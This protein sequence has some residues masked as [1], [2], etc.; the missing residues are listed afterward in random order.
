M[1]NLDEIKEKYGQKTPFS[2]PENY[3]EQF[4]EKMMAQLPEKEVQKTPVITLWKRVK[5]I[6][7]MAAMFAA[8]IWSINLYVARKGSVQPTTAETSVVSTEHDAQSVAMT[9]SV[10]DYS[11]YEYMNENKEN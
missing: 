9:M 6:L 3:F 2:V 11:L 8:A 4:S 1:N 5:P 7:Y 10:D